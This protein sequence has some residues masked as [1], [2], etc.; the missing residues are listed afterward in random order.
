MRLTGQ[1]FPRDGFMTIACQGASFTVSQPCGLRENDPPEVML[2][3]AE[4]VTIPPSAI[5]TV[6]VA[7]DAEILQ[8]PSSV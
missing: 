2:R 1:V 7:A 6:K 4:K 8:P 3:S 5:F